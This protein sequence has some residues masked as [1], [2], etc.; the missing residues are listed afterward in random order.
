MS[1]KGHKSKAKATGKDESKTEY[2]GAA[3]FELER[4]TLARVLD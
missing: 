2:L 1:D 4:S 3:G